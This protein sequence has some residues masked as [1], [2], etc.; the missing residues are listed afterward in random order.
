MDVSRP[1]PDRERDAIGRLLAAN[2][3]L[4]GQ[5]LDLLKHALTYYLWGE[6]LAPLETLP[7]KSFFQRSVY[8]VLKGV[9]RAVK[10]SSAHRVR[11]AV[12]FQFDPAKR[13]WAPTGRLW[14]T[15]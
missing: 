9:E 10:L 2:D 13:I 8:R 12:H 7:Q 4:R 11:L 14:Q 1:E 3:D 5:Y 6:T 15:R